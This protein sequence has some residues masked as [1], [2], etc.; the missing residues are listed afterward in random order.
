MFDGP[1]NRLLPAFRMS[2]LSSGIFR[3]L[4]QMVA[5]SLI[6][7]GQGFPYLP[8]CIYYYLAGLIDRAMTLVSDADLSEQV[9]TLVGEVCVY[10]WVILLQE[11][12]ELLI[13][14]TQP[15]LNS[16]LTTCSCAN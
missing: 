4:G 11:S 16:I 10:C 7:D 5:H 1:A 13:C 6:L 8:E 3:V 9:K 14:G 2:N 12:S 15:I